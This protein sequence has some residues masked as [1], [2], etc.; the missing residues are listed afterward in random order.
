MENIDPSTEF[1][2][3]TQF[4]NIIEVSLQLNN[5]PAPEETPY[6][7]KY[8]AIEKLKKLLANN[9]PFNFIVDIVLGEIYAEVEQTSDSVRSYESALQGLANLKE[10]EALKFGNYFVVV[11]NMLGLSYINR[12]LNDEGL[13]CFSK[14]MDIYEQ[15][16]KIKFEPVYH[17]RSESPGDKTFR[18][19]YQ[20]GINPD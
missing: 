6:I 2:L 17:N 3:R 10:S 15:L 4:Q 19:Y 7:Y 18:H 14:A 9:T 12:D 11:Y 13:G 16:Q 1:W 5:N 8:E 20:G